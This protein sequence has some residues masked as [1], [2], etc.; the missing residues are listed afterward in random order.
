VRTTISDPTA[1]VAPNLVQRHFHAEAVNQLWVGDITY[2]PTGE[3]WHYLAVLLDVYSRKVVGW[4]FAGHLRADLTR[5]ALEMALF[6]RRPTAGL[7]HHTGRGSQYTAQSYQQLLIQQEI[8]CSMGR[9]GQCLDNAMA[10]S[11]FATLKAELVARVRWMTGREARCAIF[12]YLEV[13]YNRQRRHSAL[14]YQS[15]VHFE[16]QRLAAKA[17]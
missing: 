16:E 14:G 15:P 9:K 8:T 7:V 6:Q 12:D 2:L 17:A 5:D 10:E 13:F 11:F 4:A 3:G 1:T